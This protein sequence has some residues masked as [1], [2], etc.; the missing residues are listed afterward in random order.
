MEQNQH[1]LKIGCCGFPLKKEDYFAYFDI[2]E[3]QQ[4]FYQLPEHR[5]ANKWRSLAPENF[6]FSMKAW[7]LI[8][9]LPSSPTYRRTKLVI[10]EDKKIR[11]GSF[12]P[13]AEVFAAWEQTVTIAKILQARMI[14][15]QC[16]ASFKPIPEN[17]KNMHQFFSQ[18]NREAFLLGWE[19]RG[20]WDEQIINDICSEWNLIHVIDPFKNNSIPQRI[21]YW[22]LHGIGGYGYQYTQQDLKYLKQMVEQKNIAET[23][24]FFNNAFMFQDALRFKSMFA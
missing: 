16:P 12:K 15:F 10:S 9:H 5:I 23:Y 3:I 11:Y 1:I 2:I 14:I 7:Q 18:L 24:I 21:R 17:I 22:R 8:T 4:T 20:A 6:I 13:T 19:P